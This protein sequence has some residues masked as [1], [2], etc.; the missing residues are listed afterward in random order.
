MATVQRIRRGLFITLLFAAV[1]A[2]AHAADPLTL[3]LLK[4]LRDQMISSALESAFTQKPQTAEPPPASTA[5]T[6]VY[7]VNAE[8]LRGMI[9]AGFV[10]LT[11][12]QRTEVY[13]HLTRMLADPKNA[14][15]RPMIIQELA[16]KAEAVR[17]A[18]ERLAALTPA[19]KRAI[20][21][22]ARVEF[23]RLPSAER[24]QMAQLLRSG[25]V[26]IP[27]DL[28]DLI[29]AELAAARTVAETSSAPSL[30]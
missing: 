10:H 25:V 24:E 9:D 17:S 28:N 7:G 11:P 30:Q 22:D 21:A 20:A 29:L 13:E 2:P 4:M 18:H 16:L 15:A 12:G 23:E 26:P 3:F 5:L 14:Q 27:G 8:Q 6:G 19:E 1:A